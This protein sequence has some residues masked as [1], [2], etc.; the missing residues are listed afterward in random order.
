MCGVPTI[1]FEIGAQATLIDIAVSLLRS[2]TR[3]TQQVL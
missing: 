3:P 1:V 2:L